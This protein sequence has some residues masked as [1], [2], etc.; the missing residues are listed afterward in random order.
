MEVQKRATPI[1]SL[2]VGHKVCLQL[3]PFGGGLPPAD[4]VEAHAGACALHPLGRQA[5]HTMRTIASALIAGRPQ[6]GHAE[7]GRVSFCGAAARAL[8]ACNIRPQSLLEHNPTGSTSSNTFGNSRTPC[9]K[10]GLGGATMRL[11]HGSGRVCTGKQHLAMR[12]RRCCRLR[13][14]EGAHA[15]S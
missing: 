6:L 2:T 1:V 10:H 4:T 7:A 13:A 5:A 11:T 12:C 8:T 15:T 14:P 3:L 9:S